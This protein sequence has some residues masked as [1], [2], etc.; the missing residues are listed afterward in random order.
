MQIEPDTWPWDPA[1]VHIFR[2]TR[3]VACLVALF[4]LTPAAVLAC[5]HIFLLT[6]QLEAPGWFPVLATTAMLLGALGHARGC[7][8]ARPPFS[9]PRTG[10]REWNCQVPY[11]PLLLGETA[12]FLQ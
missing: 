9:W 8:G 3:A 10:T 1:S 11:S 5:A 7:V 2:V 6:R 4:L 12:G